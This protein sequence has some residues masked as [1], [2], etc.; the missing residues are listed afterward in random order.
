ML[1]QLLR[2]I[3]IP[4]LLQLKLWLQIVLAVSLVDVL[5]QG[6]IFWQEKKSD[7]ESLCVESFTVFLCDEFDIEQI[8]LKNEADL[9]GDA[10]VSRG[11]EDNLFKHSVFGEL[12]GVLDLGV[13]LL[14]SHHV[15]VHHI[16]N[17]QVEDPV[18]RVLY[19]QGIPHVQLESLISLQVDQLL[20]TGETYFQSAPPVLEITLAVLF[21]HFLVAVDSCFLAFVFKLFYNRC[22]LLQQRVRLDYQ[23][24]EHLD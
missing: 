17:V 24:L 15:Q 3:C 11:D 8:F 9:C 13:E 23:R 7:V 2:E 14:L 21:Y 18:L 4:L 20:Q 6:T 19:A 5:R 12:V 10:E 22:Q 1:G 16:A